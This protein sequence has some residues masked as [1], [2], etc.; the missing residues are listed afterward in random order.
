MIGDQSL[1]IKVT[2]GAREGG[3]DDIKKNDSEAAQKWTR[4]E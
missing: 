2:T 3:V 4:A 1:M